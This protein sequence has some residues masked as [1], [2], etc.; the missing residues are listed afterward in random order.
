MKLG[1]QSR[2]A[3][4]RFIGVV[5]LVIGVAGALV[6]PAEM[7]AFYLFE[8]GGRFHYEGVGF[9]SLMFA[10]IAVQIAGYY[11]IAV[12]CIPLGYGH[13]KL[14]WWAR[15]IMMTLL[16]DWL[17]MGLPLSLVALMMLVTF[18][19]QSA[20]SL[21]FVALGFLLLYPV[22][23]VLMLRF[24]RDSATQR[25][26]QTGDVAPRWLATTPPAVLVSGSLLMFLAVLL[27]FPLLFEGF[28]PLF[29]RIMLGLP[30]ILLVVLSIATAVILTWGVLRRNYWMW[31][32]TLVFLALLTSSC[33][34]TF[35][36]LSP[37]E[38]LARMRLAPLEVEALSGIPM[39]G[40]HLALFFGWIPLATLV[41][42]AVSYRHFK[43]NAGRPP[44]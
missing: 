36:A 9:G 38:I 37:H 44:G 23:P 29:G 30:G 15:P 28:F 26:F 33:W 31:L 10:N 13:V 25:S 22:L 6:G 11:I 40:T 12:L 32:G 17:I 5:L 1:D 24:Y 14:R 19:P 8:E 42:V 27:H 2:I 16:V 34:A 3:I 4:I 39:R 18:K 43:A 7:Y 35:P 41:A 20:I 21:P